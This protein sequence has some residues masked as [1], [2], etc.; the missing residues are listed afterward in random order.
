MKRITYR[1]NKR[2]NKLKMGKITLK[3]KMINNQNII[4]KITY[5]KLR[6]KIHLILIRVVQILKVS[7]L[8]LVVKV[9]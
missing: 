9:K 7:R 4:L 1:R 5:G 8:I 2:T 6:N 3:N